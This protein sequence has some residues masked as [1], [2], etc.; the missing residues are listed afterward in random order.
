MINEEAHKDKDNDHD[1]GQD[2]DQNQYQDQ[3]QGLAHLA[4]KANIC[5]QPAVLWAS[6]NWPSSSLNLVSGSSPSSG[7]SNNHDR[8][9]GLVEDGD[10]E[11]LHPL[12]RVVVRPEGE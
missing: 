1:Q 2:N 8:P 5:R 6:P 3:D 10:G 7:S 9:E 4:Q 12:N 11:L